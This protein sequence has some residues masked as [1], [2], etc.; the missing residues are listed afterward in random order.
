[1]DEIIKDCQEKMQKTVNSLSSNLAPIRTGRASPAILDKIVIEY[2]G[3]MM[4]INQIATISSPEPRLLVIKPYDQGD[5]KAII[6]AINSSDLGLNP[7]NDGN[8]IR[9]IIPALNEERRKELTK[10]AKKYA[11]DAKIAIRNIRRD[12]IDD[13]K[14]DKEI[15]EDLRKKLESEIQKVTD[16]TIIKI[17]GL[18]TAK[19]KEI[20]SI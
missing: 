6:A 10:L 9:L 17:D 7:I 18:C 12:Y 13:V 8:S 3:D 5:V 11:E 4:P 19:E 14:K 1:M 15:P 16:E 2:Y 20:M